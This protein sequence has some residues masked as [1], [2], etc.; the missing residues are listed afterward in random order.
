MGESRNRVAGAYALTTFAPII[1]GHEEELRTLIDNLPMGSESP[2]ARLDI[3]HL[4]RI[5][6]FDQLVHQGPKHDLDHLEFKY[7]VFTSSFDGDLDTYLDLICDR[8]PTEA[9]GWWSHCVGY[10]G[11]ADRAAFRSWIKTHQRHTNLFASAYHG[12]TVAGV[13][14]SLALR[15]QLVDFAADAQGLDAAALQERFLATFG[16]AGR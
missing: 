8:I 2:L 14:E 3:L 6:I 4:S 10:P 1:P 5:Q 9:D 16:K 7:L 15:D 12:G 11:T 13:R